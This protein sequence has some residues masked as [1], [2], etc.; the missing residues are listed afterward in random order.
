MLSYLDTRQHSG[1]MVLG[2]LVKQ[3]PVNLLAIPYSN[4]S[5]AQHNADSNLGSRHTLMG[6]AYLC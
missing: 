6:P 3:L 5:R 4:N 2:S 1:H